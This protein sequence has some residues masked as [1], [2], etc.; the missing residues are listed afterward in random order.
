MIKNIKM[1]GLKWCTKSKTVPNRIYYFIFLIMG[2]ILHRLFGSKCQCAKCPELSLLR[3]PAGGEG[4][5]EGGRG[6][7]GRGPA[8]AAL[9]AIRVRVNR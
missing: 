1:K 3:C 8:R 4:R 9:W 2:R 7:G 6:V 5:D